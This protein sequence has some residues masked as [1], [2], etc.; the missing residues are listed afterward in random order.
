MIAPLR[1]PTPV[2]PP[3]ASLPL[4]Q[5]RRAVATMLFDK[6]PQLVDV[7]LPT[8]RAWKAWLVALWVLIVVVAYFWLTRGHGH[9]DRF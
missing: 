6:L 4:R 7:P 1:E 8:I 3:A 2:K 5:A 9:V